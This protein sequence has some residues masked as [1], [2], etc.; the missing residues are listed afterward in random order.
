MGKKRLDSG[1]ALQ[2]ELTG[3]AHGL[4]V[5]KGRKEGRTMLD[6]RSEQLAVGSAKDQERLG[7][8]Q[9]GVCVAG[10]RS[11]NLFWLC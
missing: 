8:E 7:M 11:G 9:C 6:V 5:G 3:C 10:E 4:D 1:C 2:I